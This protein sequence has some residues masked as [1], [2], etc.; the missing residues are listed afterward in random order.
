M[1]KPQESSLLGTPLKMSSQSKQSKTDAQC[2]LHEHTTYYCMHGCTH[3]HTHRHRHTQTHTD[4]HTQTHTHTDTHTCTHTH[5]HTHMHT[6]A[7]THTHAHTQQAHTHT[8]GTHNRY[9]HTH[10]RHTHMHTS[11]SSSS[12]VRLAQSKGAGQ[13]P[14]NSLGSCFDM[15]TYV[16][17]HAL[18]ETSA[19]SVFCSV[20]CTSIWSVNCACP[21]LLS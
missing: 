6:H 14:G 8:T 7:D 17:T 20:A 13:D 12:S 9:I 11:S 5:R 16:S 2:V 4:T 21:S 10:N 19:S 1:L 18:I 15:H 3:A